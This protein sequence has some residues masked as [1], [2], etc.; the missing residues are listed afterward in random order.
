MES[1][2]PFLEASPPQHNFLNLSG[3][4]GITAA[5]PSYVQSLDLPMIKE[6]GKALKEKTSTCFHVHGECC[7]IWFVLFVWI[8]SPNE[9]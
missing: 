7:F 4:S 5:L 9:L 3:Q 1:H 2:L 6:G 8:P